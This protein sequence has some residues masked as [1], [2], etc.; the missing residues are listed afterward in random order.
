MYAGMIS[1]ESGL[2]GARKRYYDPVLR[3][4][5]SLDPFV[6]SPTF[7]ASHNPYAYAA[8]NPLRYVDAA[9]REREPHALR[10]W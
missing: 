5:I 2:Y 6:G 10:H 1:D 3:R 7:P 4:F 8:N 9:G